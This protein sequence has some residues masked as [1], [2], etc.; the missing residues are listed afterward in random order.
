[1]STLL[2][3]LRNNSTSPF[4]LFL[5]TLS[6]TLSIAQ[7]SI[8]GTW[9]PVYTADMVPVAA[10]NLPDGKIL[11]W[12]AYDAY[13]FGSDRGQ[14]YTSIFDPSTNQFSSTLITHTDHDMFCPGIANIGNGEIVITGGTSSDKTT[15]FNPSSNSFRSG[16]LMNT[17]RGYH[18]MT[19][20]SDGRVFTLGGSWSGGRFNKKAEVWTEAT[21]WVTLD[22]VDSE[23]TVRQGAPDPR[24]IYRD[25]NHAWLWAGP[26]GRVFQAGPGTNMHWISTSGA[27]DVTDVGNRGTDAYAMNGNSVMYEVGKIL[28]SGGA[29]AYEDKTLNGEADYPASNRSYVIDISN[30]NSATVTRSGN[31]N[32]TRVLHNSVVLPNGEVVITGGQC[33]PELFTDICARYTAEIW[34]S[35]TGNWREAASMLTPRTYHSV[36]LLMQD[37]RVWV[38]GGGLC[39]GCNAN[40]P[41]AEI[42]TPPYLYEGNTLA[43]RPAISSAP[44]TATYNST[45]TV[46]TSR[47]V[48]EFVLVRL[49]SAT[50]SV[51][52]E[53]RRV[54]LNF[55]RR[56]GNTYSVRVPNSEWLPPGNYFLFALDEGVPSVAKVIQI[57][58]DQSPGTGLNQTIANG[59]YFIESLP[60]AQHLAS[61]SF[62]V[63]NVRMVPQE[64]GNDQLWEITHFSNNVYA[65]KNVATGRFLNVEGIACGNGT[66]VITWTHSNQDNSRWII[67]K[68]GSE[69]FFRPLHCTSQALDNGNGPNKSVLTWRYSTGNNNQ[70]FILKSAINNP[71]GGNG[72]CPTIRLKEPVVS[73]AGGQ[74]SGTAIIQDNQRTIQ[75]A[76]NAWK[77]IPFSYTLTPNTRLEFDFKAN[78]QGEEHSIGF[79]NNLRI[80]GRYRFELYGTQNQAGIIR[81][82]D[83]YNGSGSYK[84]Y[85]IPV[86]QYYTGAMSYLFFLMDNDRNPSVGDSYFSNITVYEDT[87][88][89]GIN[90]DCEDGADVVTLY[91]HCNYRG[92]NVSLGVGD[93]PSIASAGLPNDNLSSIKVQPGY[94][95]IL[96]RNTNF[97]GTSLTLQGDDACLIDNGFNDVTS[98][99]QIRPTGNITFSSANAQLDIDRVPI[100]FRA[101]PT[102]DRKAILEWQYDRAKDRDVSSY[103][104]QYYDKGMEA[105]ID[106]HKVEV[107]N[108]TSKSLI[109]YIHRTPIV[110]ENYYQI[111]IVFTDGEEAYSMNRVVAFEEEPLPISLFPNP[112][113]NDLELDLS[114][115]KNEAIHYFIINLQGQVLSNGTFGENHQDIELLTLKNFPAGN[116]ILYTRPEYHRE[117]SQPF[118]IND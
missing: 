2:Q 39:G 71:G 60:T 1:M 48:Q 52:N 36:A 49:S 20:L 25:D 108:L 86:G 3:R 28:T 18:T 29:Q 24:G 112:T 45:L 27:G 7:H 10:T 54:P 59:V 101:T 21:G 43:S 14:T 117:I 32:Q 8:T 98:S 106:L 105:F 50:H 74:D 100:S 73:Y 80:T 4:I 66:N 58:A 70:R 11:S 40:H 96:Y 115:Y 81:D 99:F 107:N 75:V 87:N 61:P 34:N 93:Y 30:G 95:I 23:Q 114:H 9:S 69:Y 16:P 46:S 41:D 89:N 65:V 72:T 83:N 76:N 92:R 15:I 63:N 33:K 97:S 85:S 53:Q 17:A 113:Q 56:S 102:V 22:N 37:G 42:F 90:D 79:D 57:G 78:S 111:K 38:A 104:F 51:N 82:F 118:I 55:T 64:T 31:L 26:N 12:S 103:T 109:Q 68:E 5:L 77:A 44:T 67:S 91:Y 19:T 35:T 62:D 94:E 47:R 116:Y 110:G 88:G 6:P 84:R 13:R